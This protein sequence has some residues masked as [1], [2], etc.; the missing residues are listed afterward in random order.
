MGVR[1]GCKVAQKG[2]RKAGN[3]EGPGSETRSFVLDP[4]SALGSAQDSSSQE[5][6]LRW[7]ESAR[8]DMLG[9]CRQEPG[10]SGAEAP[11]VQG[12]P[13]AKGERVSQ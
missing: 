6:P 2:V 10:G 4:A 8:E 11:R 1:R 5:K 3:A 9:S 7:T 13:R 12:K